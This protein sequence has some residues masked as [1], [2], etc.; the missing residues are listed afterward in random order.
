MRK[1]SNLGATIIVKT[2]WKL[3]RT[4]GQAQN[5]PM[6]FIDQSFGDC[7]LLQVIPQRSLFQ[8]AV[9]KRML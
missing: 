2:N 6:H 4:L 8:V 9:K 7:R 1:T 5:R 3:K